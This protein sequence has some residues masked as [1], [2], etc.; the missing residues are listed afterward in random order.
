MNALVMGFILTVA[1]LVQAVVPAPPWLGQ[2]KLPALAAVVVYYTLARERRD[3]LWAAIMAGLLQDGM[4]L[5]PFGYSSFAFGLLA[6]HIARFRDVVFVHESITH[7]LFGSWMAAGSTLVL[8]VLLTSTG[9]IEWTVGQAGHKAVG[10]AALGLVATPWIFYGCAR[11]DR[12][13]GLVE[14]TDSSWQE[15]H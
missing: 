10:A 3:W 7:M 6:I 9:L 11:L 13:M 12:L 4:S 5:I 1:A 15:L 14:S 2:A 8:Y